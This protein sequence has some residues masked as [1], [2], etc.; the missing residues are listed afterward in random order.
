MP[1]IIV[2]QVSQVQA[3]IERE[4]LLKGHV[5]LSRVKSMSD[6]ERQARLTAVRSAVDCA[7]QEVILPQRFS[8]SWG[9]NNPSSP[10]PAIADEAPITSAEE[11][12]S[13][14]QSMKK[15]HLQKEEI[16]PVREP[17]SSEFS[18]L[19]NRVARMRA[20]ATSDR[21]PASRGQV[22]F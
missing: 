15:Q 10:R 7:K 20:A 3:A 9:R 13:V 1:L 4:L 14:L 12:Q 18:S 16:N 11:Q 22:Q 21:S 5:Y 19:R 6:E 17:S 8:S 2:S